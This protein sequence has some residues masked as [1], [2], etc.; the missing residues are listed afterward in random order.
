VLKEIVMHV[1]KFTLGAR[2]AGLFAV[3]AMILIPVSPATADIDRDELSATLELT[4]VVRDF[5]ERTATGGHPDFEQ[6]PS[7][8]FGIY[9]GN[10]DLQLGAD[11]K[12]VFTGNGWKLS[13]QWRDAANRPIC[14]ALYDTDAGDV[15][16]AQGVSNSG[17][18]SSAE[19]FASWYNDV[20]GV[21]MSQPLTLTLLLQDDGSYV[22]DDKYD[23]LYS[24]LGGFFPIED[25]LFGNPGGSP[26]RNF[27]FTFELHTEF[28]YDAS[29]SQI[30]K[31]IGDDDVWVFINGELVIDLG[32]VHSAEQQY[33]ELNRL[34]LA[35][36]ENYTL[37]FFFAERHRTQ[38]NFRMQT[39]IA[40]ESVELPAVTAAFD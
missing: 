20:P 10:I 9:C 30:F 14:Y 18:I 2:H 1:P 39:N 31:F 26:N 13:K 28:T 23:P 34:G 29:A 27:H 4:G 25:E 19:S 36:G 6:K 22:F 24:D 7:A 8:G 17:G 3:G 40:L 21:N 5:R 37:D 16:G 11:G 32:G 33:V 15:L 35:D 38:S 12:P